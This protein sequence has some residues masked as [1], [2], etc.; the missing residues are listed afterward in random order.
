M[1]TLLPSADLFHLDAVTYQT[2]RLILRLRTRRQQ[3]ASP[4]CQTLSNKLHSRYLRHLADLPW[5]GI[6]VQFDLQVRKFFCRNE[7]CQQHIFCERLAEVALADARQTVRLNSYLQQCGWHLG[8][9]LRVRLTRLTGVRLGADA[10]L[11]RVRKLPAQGVPRQVRVLG[12][13]DFSFRRGDPYGTILVDHEQHCVVDLWASREA[14]DLADWLGAH[15]EV[16]IITRDRAPAYAEG[17]TQGAANAQQIA[18]RW[19]ILHN[20]TAAYEQLIQHHSRAIR[21]CAQELN[22]Q[23]RAASAAATG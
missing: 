16:E 23:F 8:G 11:Q 10:I 9:A 20:L 3:A 21:A 2:G 19:H 18:D 5:A 22:E 15:P 14:K 7:A 13:D 17:A 1:K 12:G 4:S 6:P